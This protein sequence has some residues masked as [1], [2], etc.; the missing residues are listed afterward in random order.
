MGI[1]AKELYEIVKGKKVKY[2]EPKHCLL[3]LQ[4]MSSKEKGTFSAFCVQAHISETTFYRWIHEH[5]IFRECYALAKMIALE[6]WEAQGRELYDLEMDART[7]SYK[8]QIWQMQGWSRFGIAKVA[9]LRLKLDPESNPNEHYHQLIKQASEG[10]FTAGELKQ[11][12]E[13]INVGLNAHQIIKLQEEINN[14]KS[15]LA[16]MKENS[17]NGNNSLPAKGIA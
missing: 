17:N 16:L 2:D 8:H 9:K 15:D 13:A 12:M 4:V 3:L 5:E 7:T 11:L 1:D 10:A 6:N 14:L